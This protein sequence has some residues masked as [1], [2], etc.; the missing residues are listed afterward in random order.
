M[1]EVWRNTAARTPGEPPFRRPQSHGGSH[2]PSGLY[3]TPPREGHLP[4]EPQRGRA[5]RTFAAHLGARHQ[6]AGGTSRPRPQIVDY[7]SLSRRPPKS[8]TPPTARGGLFWRFDFHENV[9]SLT[10]PQC[11]VRKPLPRA[12]ALIDRHDADGVA[13]CGGR[14]SCQARSMTRARFTFAV[15]SATLAGGR[16][17]PLTR[18]RRRHTPSR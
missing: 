7:R 8:V 12:P 2:P 13:F 3:P 15:G 1:P 6:K 18:P 16:D 10:L 17:E 9:V 11:R 14:R 4:Q 5:G